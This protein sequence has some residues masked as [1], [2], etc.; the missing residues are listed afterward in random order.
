V[1]L[2]ESLTDL[3]QPHGI[4]TGANVEENLSP[5]LFTFAARKDACNLAVCI[6]NADLARAKA[7]ASRGVVD[8]VLLF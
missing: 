2:L 3:T 8:C 1:A 5:S 6:Q 4:S 7:S